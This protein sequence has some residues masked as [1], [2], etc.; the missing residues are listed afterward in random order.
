MTTTLGYIDVF[1]A[2]PGGRRRRRRI[3]R[4]AVAG[5]RALHGRGPTKPQGLFVGPAVALA[6]VERRR[7]QAV[8]PG[9]SREAVA[10]S[11][12]SAAI[13]AAPVVAA[14]KI[15]QMLRSV[16]VLAGHDMLSALAVQRLVDRQLPVHGRGGSRRWPSRSRF[17]SSGNRDSTRMR[18][19]TGFRTLAWSPCCFWQPRS[20]G[21]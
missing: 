13:V 10:A 14:G 9:E 5:G 1:F 2:I 8:A 12:L 19:R 18:W 17:S 4:T 3:L 16:A 11:A 6:L 20:C 7:R 15:F 21:L